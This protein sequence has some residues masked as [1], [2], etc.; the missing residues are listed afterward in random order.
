MSAFNEGL[1]KAAALLDENA[2]SF[3][4]IRDPGMANH[5]RALA[6]RIRALKQEGSG[7]EAGEVSRSQTEAPS[8]RSQALEEAAVQCEKRADIYL[9][10]GDHTLKLEAR[11]CAKVIRALSLPAPDGS[12]A[13]GAA[14]FDPVAKAR[15]I[16]RSVRGCT[17]D[18]QY[19]DLLVQI[20]DALRA[21]RDSALKQEGGCPGDGGEYTPDQRRVAEYIAMLTGGAVGGGDD[22]VGFLIASHATLVARGA[23][24]PAPP[25][26]EDK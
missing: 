7:Q 15:T 5:D 25:G 12:S 23:P 3:N 4:K 2:Q 13:A 6:K 14:P 16:A 9:E 11:A 22:P 21:A 19:A 10:R 17:T 26:G 8:V 24:L 18:A 20:E 1:E